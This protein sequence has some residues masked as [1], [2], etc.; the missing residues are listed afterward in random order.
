M[1]TFADERTAKWPSVYEVRGDT[2][3]RARFDAGQRETP[4]LD[5]RE[6]RVLDL[7]RGSEGVELPAEPVPW[8]GQ[9]TVSDH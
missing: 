5:G 2:V 9:R 1:V 6:V 8:P 3:C 4:Q 7:G